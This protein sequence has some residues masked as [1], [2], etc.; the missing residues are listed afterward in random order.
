MAREPLD[1]Y[2]VM[3]WTFLDPIF[4]S[5]P[6]KARLAL[7]RFR[8]AGCNGAACHG[9]FIAPE[10]FKKYIRR[11][12]LEKEFPY[13]T[14]QMDA[15]PFLE[16][17]FPFWVENVCRALTWDW[18][19]GKPVLRRQ[20]ETFDRERDRRVF[21]KR[22][23]VNDP[24]VEAA[25]RDRLAE[26]MKVLEPARHLTMLYDLRD[27]P[28]VCSFMLAGDV[29]FCDH[30]MKR[31]RSWLGERYADLAALN[32][33]WGTQ[34]E[35]W[36]QVEPIATQEALE[37]RAA[38]DYNFS[39]WADHREFMD[40]SF[41]RAVRDYTAEFKKH[42]PDAI[43]GLEGTQCPWAFGGWDFPR[44]VPEL[45]WAEP[46]AWACSPDLFRSL[47]RSREVRLIKTAGLGADPVTKEVLLWEYVFQ[48]GGYG[49][50]IGW[51]SNSAMKT[52]QEDWPLT[53]KT[54]DFAPVYFELRSGAP[55]L[56]QLTE[57][58]SS[59]VA[60]HISQPSVR[61]DFIVSVPG[62]W[63]SVAAA[64]PDRFDA[65]KVREAWWKLLEDRGLRPV[66]VTD[67]QIAAGELGKR[68]VKVL[69]LP[70]SIA[71]SDAVAAAM[72]EFVAAGG[73]LLADS[74]AGRM[75][76]HC[77]DRE[78]G[79]LDE[80]FGIR[81][82]ETD[83]YHASSQRASLDYDAP[84]GETPV[85]GRGGLRAECALVEER[86][87][88]LPGTRVLG[89]TEY[90][91][92]PLG[93][94]R[95]H[96]KGRALLLNCAPLDYLR[97]R[98]TVV[99]GAGLQKFF[100]GALDLAG[101]KPELEITSKGSGEHLAGWRI[102]PFAHGGARYFGLIPDLGATQDTLGATTAE[103][104]RAACQARLGFPVA[105][106]LY[107]ARWGTYFGEGDSAVDR[108]EPGSIKL[109]AVMP[110]RVEA[111]ELSLSGGKASAKVKASGKPGEHVLRFDLFDAS[112]RRLC[113]SG[114]NV[115]AAGGKAEWKPGELPA[116]GKLVCRDV[117]TGVGAEIPLP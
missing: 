97:A 39:P 66:F 55:K 78:V 115:V 65:F 17:D 25:T 81:R 84:A 11:T 89:C 85:W 112:G 116:G 82:L 32:A 103:G 10:S 61:A 12:G 36:D 72:R 94:L 43:C 23:C 42:D 22:A 16:N 31:M 109:Y 41:V 18:E 69:V 102:F 24:E 56:L 92:T 44:L 3:M 35:S 15:S 76:E 73:T 107:E 40:E 104:G 20:Y 8:E 1:D 62:R 21:V 52:D 111:L 29:C 45:D 14:P 19:K 87:E 101:I 110:Y 27:E 108:F 86:I 70:R 58:L 53:E 5:G 9:A 6:E 67:A 75:D 49:G 91:D 54:R 33:E 100:G 2:Y 113:E 60:V 51:A 117:A 88:P 13:D 63:R 90:T 74:F 68:G 77:R 34:F 79:A 99:G 106:H 96:G 28:S 38:G 83:G 105:G 80:L 4:K 93:L 48:A 30:C 7:Q 59:P 95:E 98:R 57:E 114:A 47:K 71:V 64:E 37:R 50:A 46:Y 26:M